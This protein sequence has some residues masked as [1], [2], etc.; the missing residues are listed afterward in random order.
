MQNNFDVHKWKLDNLLEES[1][2]GADAAQLVIDK[3]RSISKKLSDEDMDKFIIDIASF[4]DCTPPSYRLNESKDFLSKLADDFEANHPE[5]R[6]I[7]SNDKIKF[8]GGQQAL[9][10]FGDKISGKK[11]GEYEVFWTEDDE[12]GELISIVRSD[13]I[14]RGGS[15]LEEKD[16]L[17][18]NIHAKRNRGEKPS[19]GNSNAHK[20]A[21]KA[22]NKIKE[23]EHQG[24]NYKWPMSK[25]TKDR[26][27]ADVAAQKT[28]KN[29]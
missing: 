29:D 16:G 23:T 22:G 18:A 21:V 15:N 5:L 6:V 1:R 2:T 20:D 14:S 19:H 27:E 3:I 26:K 10:N 11:F 8:Y 25:A 9:V 7:L 12:R 17:W 28:N 24:S 13:S 4:I